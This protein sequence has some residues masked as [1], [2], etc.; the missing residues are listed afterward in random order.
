MA[1]TETGGSTGPIRHSCVYLIEKKGF[2]TKEQRV[3]NEGIDIMPS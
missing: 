3:S 1:M 2:L